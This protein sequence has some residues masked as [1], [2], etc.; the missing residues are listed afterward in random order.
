MSTIT[1]NDVKGAIDYAWDMWG[2]NEAR[3]F[4][5]KLESGESVNIIFDKVLTC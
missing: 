5:Y 1:L 2:R 3:A 4:S